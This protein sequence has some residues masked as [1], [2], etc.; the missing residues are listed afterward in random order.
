LSFH[1]ENAIEVG[2][3]D[4]IKQLS[5]TEKAS[6]KKIY[7]TL[8]YNQAWSGLVRPGWLNNILRNS[9]GFDNNEDYTEQQHYAIVIAYITEL[10]IKVFQDELYQLSR[11]GFGDIHPWLAGDYQKWLSDNYPKLKEIEIRGNI[12]DNYSEN[13]EL[14]NIFASYKNQYITTPGVRFLPLSTYIT[15]IIN[16][17][18]ILNRVFDF[19]GSINGIYENLALQIGSYDANQNLILFGVLK[20]ITDG[21]TNYNQSKISKTGYNIQNFKTI[22]DA[23]TLSFA[24]ENKYMF[25]LNLPITLQK[26][27]NTNNIT[28]SP[29]IV[30]TSIPSISL[31]SIEAKLNN[32][33][34]KSLGSMRHDTFGMSFRDTP[35]RDYYKM[36]LSW[37][38]LCY[39]KKGSNWKNNIRL[40]NYPS[41]YKTTM[42]I[43]LVYNYLINHSVSDEISNEYSN[44]P[45]LDYIL[46]K[47]GTIG[48]IDKYIKKEGFYEKLNPTIENVKKSSTTKNKQYEKLQKSG[49][50]IESNETV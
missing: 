15:N 20:D 26:E 7:D 21:D 29:Y 37:F 13:N 40:Y 33:I 30:S 38:N 48:E 19:S 39:Y 11:V 3:L 47:E 2:R 49:E 4:R 18:S 50:T 35:N 17:K 14:S 46:K 25:N 43:G 16:F 24:Y 12:R 45:R 27:L 5:D 32:R 34:V 9:K 44:G 36:F 28:D 1:L 6:V 8:L 22:G 10:A 41:E 23:K 42:K 31:D